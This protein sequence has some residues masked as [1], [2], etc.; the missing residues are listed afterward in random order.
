MLSWLEPFFI[1]FYIFCSSVCLADPLH[2]SLAS[3]KI[4]KI[5]VVADSILLFRI[6]NILIKE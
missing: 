3:R 1:L 6:E 4:K 5:E 2:N